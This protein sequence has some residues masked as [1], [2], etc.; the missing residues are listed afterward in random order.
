MRYQ[1]FCGE[2]PDI[3][4]IPG[5][6]GDDAIPKVAQAT[7]EN[8]ELNRANLRI[9]WDLYESGMI[10]TLT[11]Y[12][13]TEQDSVSDF[14]RSLGENQD[15]LYCEG[16]AY[17]PGTPNNCPA[18]NPANLRFQTGVY[19]RELGGETEEF[20]QELRF[21]SA[22]DRQLRYT[23][24]GYAYST[25]SKGYPGAIL[26]TNPIPGVATPIPGQPGVGVGLPPFGVVEGDPTALMIGT[27]IFYDSFTP[28]GGIDPLGRQ[29]SE[30]DTQGWALF[31]G[32]D[33]DF[34]DQL[35]GRAEI[36]YSQESQESTV[37][38]YNRCYTTT[39]TTGALGSCIYPDEQLALFGDDR[40]DLRDGFTSAVPFFGADCLF[41]PVNEPDKQVLGSPGQCSGSASARFDSVTGR[42][43][44]DYMV[45]DEWMVYGSIAYGEKP[46]GVAVRSA[47]LV[48]GNS[49]SLPNIFEPETI[50]TYELGLKGAFWDGRATISSAVFYND[51]REIVLRQL[52]EVDPI[53][54]VRF[55]QP[56]SFNVNAGDADVWGVEVETNVGFM[57][58]LTGRFTVGWADATM[59]NAAQDTYR[60]FPSFAAEGFDEVA[61]DVSGNQLLRQPE[62][63]HERLAQLLGRAPRRRLGLVCQ[64][65]RQLPERRLRR[66]RQ[67]GVSSGT[68]L[69]EHQAGRQVGRVHA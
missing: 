38:R 61:G 11:G 18:N 4:G 35:T 62:W 40:Y 8:R 25:T 20:S 10:S 28:D 45:S 27:A 49:V 67:P 46:G 64:W 60:D 19:D 59:K 23:V 36:R 50:T 43:G 30:G 41:T 51:W 17:T 44:L 63:L 54:G 1:N 57:D 26:L 52:I 2:V 13:K 47:R 9:E 29:T 16:G 31:T 34:T 22:Q 53:S 58:N 39:T 12:S 21:S 66:Q 68:H 7:G 6:N 15:F 24:G 48:S 33:F 3:E 14:A 37:Y 42:V 69:R 32:V 56:T 5:L 55:E 65:R